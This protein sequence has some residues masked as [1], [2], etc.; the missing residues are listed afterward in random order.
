M[1][2]SALSPSLQAPRARGFLLLLASVSLWGFAPIGNRYFIGPTHLGFPAASYMALRYA[3]AAFC[4]TPGVIVAL[5][6]WSGRDWLRGALCGFA[7]VSVYNLL[8]GQAARSVSAGLAGLLNSTETLMILLLGCLIA[9][10]APGLRMIFAA[11]LGAA[12]IALLAASSG[13][14]EGSL[15]GILLLLGS[16]SGWAIYCVLVPPLIRKHG[17]LQTSAVTMFLGTMPLLLLGGAGLPAM[18]HA[19]TGW[20]WTF[21]LGLAIGGSVVALIAWNKGVAELGAQT[22]SWFLYLLPVFSALGGRLL[23]AE[24]LTLAELAGGVMILSSVYIAQRRR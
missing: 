21:A 7:G 22:A 19:L 20:D 3:I 4:F 14:A 6:S 1:S 24:P 12:G 11:L 13:P 8:A 23:L 9:R 16:A 17:A 10:R 15:S 5:R 2:Q 18:V